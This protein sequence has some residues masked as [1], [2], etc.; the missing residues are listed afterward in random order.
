MALAL[1]KPL[2]ETTEMFAEMCTP[3]SPG[4]SVPGATMTVCVLDEFFAV[5]EQQ[6]ALIFLRRRSASGPNGISGQ[7]LLNLSDPA[8]LILLK[9]LS[10]IW[11]TA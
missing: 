9:R 8:L 10:D 7:A 5:V 11:A 3:D 1:R 4:T 2:E 6:D